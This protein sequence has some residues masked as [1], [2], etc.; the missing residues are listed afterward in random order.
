MACKS[1]EILGIT[2]SARFPHCPPNHPSTQMCEIDKLCIPCPNPSM[3][4]LLEVCVN[5]TICS[6]KEI[7]TPIGRKLVIEGNRQIKVKYSTDDPCHSVYS[8]HFEIPFCTFI[9][10]GD[11]KHEIV[12]VCT[13]VEDIIVRCLDDR[14]LTVTSII[15]FSPV[16]EKEHECSTCPPQN[17]WHCD[18]HDPCKIENDYPCGCDE[19]DNIASHYQSGLNKYHALSEWPG[20][21]EAEVIRVDR[22]YY[23]GR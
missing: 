23:Y 13:V 22:R 2:P 15:F 12:E 9:V 18:C 6:S 4:E 21:N 10:I 14:H 20:D 7:C 1:I 5:V 19:Q 17:N 8:A 16:F 3:H 11:I